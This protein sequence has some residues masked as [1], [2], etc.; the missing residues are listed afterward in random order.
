MANSVTYTPPPAFAN[1]GIRSVNCRSKIYSMEYA[2]WP[3]EAGLGF[4]MMHPWLLLASVEQSV[5]LMR[6]LDCTAFEECVHPW[7][8]YQSSF[9]SGQSVDRAGGWLTGVPGSCAV[10]CDP[11][12]PGS[13][14]QTYLSAGGHREVLNDDG[15][16]AELTSPPTGHVGAEDQKALHTEH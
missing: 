3:Y 10:P 16:S 6:V 2:P 4:V 7:C 8:R 11:S 15:G 12:G 1:A 14:L 5:E 13:P 9:R